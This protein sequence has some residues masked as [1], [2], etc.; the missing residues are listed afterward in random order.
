MFF[1]Y[2][3]EYYNPEDSEAQG[4]AE[5]ILAKHRNG[6]TDAV[7]LELPQAVREVR[8]PRRRVAPLDRARRRGRGP[9]RARLERGPCRSQRTRLLVHASLQ[10]RGA[11]PLAGVAARRPRPGCERLGLRRR[12]ARRPRGVG[13]VRVEALGRV[14]RLAGVPRRVTTEGTAQHRTAASAARGADDRSSRRA[15]AS[16]RGTTSTASFLHERRIGW[17]SGGLLQPVGH[18]RGDRPAA[19]GPRPRRPVR[20]RSPSR[21]TITARD[22][23]ERARRGPSSARSGSPA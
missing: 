10:L 8:R 6:P 20:S 19:P 5:V 18:E 22:A 1:V 23:G 11:R 16:D 15:C 9:R 17:R 12:V 13:G 2:R 21:P 4:I 7:K 14:E 3:D